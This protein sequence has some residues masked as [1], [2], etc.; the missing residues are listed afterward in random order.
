M[1][2][3]RGKKAASPA[4]RTCHF[5]FLLSGILWLWHPLLVKAQLSSAAAEHAQR[6]ADLVSEGNW[7]EAIK[8]LS[9]AARLDPN[10]AATHAN[11]GMAYYFKGNMDA[12]VAEFRAA[13][14][15]TPD[16]VDAAHGLGLA[17]Y[18][19]G[20]VDGAA[21]AFRTSSRHNAIA[22]YNLGNVL[23][24]KGDR[25]GALE[26]YKRYLAAAPQAPESATLGE[27]V[28]KGTI[29]TPAAG[30][31]KD[32]FQHGQALLGQK[33]AKAA[34]I[35]L[36]AALRL[37]PNYVEACN[38]LGLAFR[39][40]GDLEQAIGGYKMALH[41]DPKFAVAYR[42]LAQAFEEK[43]DA[44]QAAQFYDQ[45]LLASPG[46]PDAAQVRD[47]IAQLRNVTK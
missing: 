45:Y 19:K 35:E 11:L 23:E 44:A 1:N 12:A 28:K 41:L 46:A 18:E 43:G 31:A 13:L 3:P 26:A 36:L 21:A 10:N 27:A 8:E 4:K 2:L 5:L 15:I 47:K 22:N 38:S 42:N 29:P 17:L 7:Q 34:V 33:E 40:E 30:T 16:R 24:Q 6:G 39:A 32:H 14:R 37:K 9:T 25:T 20:E